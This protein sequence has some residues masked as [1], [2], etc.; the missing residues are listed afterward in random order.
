MRRPIVK[1]VVY[2][3][4]MKPQT[5]K[6]ALI[7]AAVL[8]LLSFLSACGGSNATEAPA[9]DVP[10]PSN[11]GGTGEAVN[12]TGDPKAGAEVYTQV[13]ATCH[14]P[15]GKGGVANPGSTDGTVPEL[16][17]IDPGLV[18][19]DYKTFAVNL[20]LFLEHGSTPEGPSPEKSMVGFGDTKALTPQQIAD[21]I[22]YVISLNP[23]K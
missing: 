17:P 22:A 5:R 12:L 16:N 10:K 6:F 3:G 4:Q 20:D 8:I 18:S 21:V 23:A 9:S 11:S 2:G 19:A 7:F 1:K 15:E 13:C 14:G